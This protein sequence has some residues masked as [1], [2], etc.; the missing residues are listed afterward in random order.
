MTL[1]T[2]PSYLAASPA[3]IRARVTIAHPQ[4]RDIIQ[5][6]P[7]PGRCLYLDNSKIDEVDFSV[8]HGSPSTFATLDFHANCLVVAHGLI[9]AGGQNGELAI[10][11]FVD[12]RC[13]KT[14]AEG[15][16]TDPVAKNSGSQQPAPSTWLLRTPVG[17]SI[18]NAIA[19]RNDPFEISQH[20]DSLRKAAGPM[21]HAGKPSSSKKQRR[22][23][24]LPGEGVWLRDDPHGRAA[25]HALHLDDV[26]DQSDDHPQFDQGDDHGQHYPLRSHGDHSSE[27]AAGMRFPPRP[28]LTSDASCRGTTRIYVSNNDKSLK[29]YKLRPP[30]GVKREA[31]PRGSGAPADAAQ[32]SSLESGLPGLSRSH[33]LEFPTAVNHTSLSPDGKTLIAVGDTPDVFLYH[34]HCDGTFEK[35]ATYQATSDASFSTSW[36]PDGSK[37][38][39]ASQ[40]GVVSVWDVRSRKKLAEIKTSQHTESNDGVTDRTDAAATGADS[41]NGAARVVKFSPCGRYLAF[42]EHAT[43]F[44]IYDTLTFSSA[45]KIRIPTSF[46]SSD[47]SV[48]N[49]VSPPA[50]FPESQE[51]NASSS[52]S[53]STPRTNSLLPPRWL[54]SSSVSARA[55]ALDRAT[56]EIEELNTL[57]ESL[58]DETATLASRT[59]SLAAQGSSHD[60][61]ESARAERDGAMIAIRDAQRSLR[62]ARDRLA[63]RTYQQQRAE[64]RGSQGR[65][66]STRSSSTGAN[67]VPLGVTDVEQLAAES[68]SQAG[69]DT[70][71]EFL[72]TLA[73]RNLLSD[74][75]EE[76][77]VLD[78]EGDASRARLLRDTASS[79]VGPPSG[80]ETPLPAS[81]RAHSALQFHQSPV[82]GWGP[83]A[84]RDVDSDTHP[85]EAPHTRLSALSPAPTLGHHT[86]STSQ[87]SGIGQ[88]R[89]LRGSRHVGG[90]RLYLGDWPP[91]FSTVP[92]PAT[93]EHEAWHNI[94]GLCW[95][96]EGEYLYVASERLI[97]RYAVNDLRRP[98][99]SGQ[100]L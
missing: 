49:D 40:D 11:P 17:G 19:I 98:S 36:H 52:S 50:T 42:T 82:R 10:R 47:R 30:S 85:G 1:S 18:N 45:Q 75:D 23:S 53:S 24:H 90:A 97:C 37:F 7:V 63:Y 41:V 25:E 44:H 66:L 62:Q 80:R 2:E 84:R 33:T 64:M 46:E 9:A 12:T 14:D 54:W 95:D 28:A 94:A 58:R 22:H 51:R 67:T 74:N 77:T 93:P 61:F 48:V 57:A 69:A 59:A 3:V 13:A 73:L 70:Q 91:S 92:F 31:E 83:A 20:A 35:I 96:A 86:G 68:S 29:I 15:P 56:S 81:I 38:A 99:Q 39:V 100:L 76:E 16:V 8:P 4:L 78:V 26:Y 71:N 89:D 72:A 79:T 60:R 87:P 32:P 27:A 88:I 5:P 6:S 34:R 43:W 21:P 65:T 55:G